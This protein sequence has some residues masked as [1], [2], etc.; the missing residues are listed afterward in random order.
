ME[1]LSLI[2]FFDRQGIP[3]N[4]IRHQPKANGISSSELLS[5]AGDGETTE[6]D[7][8][9]DF[10]DDI[11]TLRNYSFISPSENETFFTMYRL[12]QLTTRPWLK[13]HGQIDKW[14]DRFISILC[15]EFPT[16]GHENW[17]RCRPLFPHVKSAMSQSQHHF[18]VCN[19]GLRC[20]S[21]VRGMLRS[22]DSSWIQ[23]KWPQN[24][25][26]KEGFY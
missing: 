5:D 22:A 25:E 23:E 13:S 10:E 15:N 21:E 24:Q 8:G 14:K 7:L 12:V 2:S 26:T 9:P 6:S 17:E 19:N 20:F 4:L 16:G 11:A 1:L 3:D 18:S